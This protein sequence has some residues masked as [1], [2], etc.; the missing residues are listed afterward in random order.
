MLNEAMLTTTWYGN[1]S[2][3]CIIPTVICISVDYVVKIRHRPSCQSAARPSQLVAFA[4]VQC[5]V[6][7]F[8]TSAF[9]RSHQ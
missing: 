3:A 9:W 8:D 7:R 2:C 6:K 5:T 1:V 4:D